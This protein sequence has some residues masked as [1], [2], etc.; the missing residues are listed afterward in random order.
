M[1]LERKNYTR[2]EEPL[3]DSDDDDEDNYVGYVSVEK[4]ETIKDGRRMSS[5]MGAGG[6]VGG[7]TNRARPLGL[8]GVRRPLGN[9][10]TVENGSYVKSILRKELSLSHHSF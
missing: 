7:T 3:S 6:M 1:R 2:V 9:S 8:L 10:P 4:Q 5:S